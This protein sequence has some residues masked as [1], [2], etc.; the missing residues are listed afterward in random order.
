[1]TTTLSL[2]QLTDDYKA[3]SQQKVLEAEVVYE[4]HVIL[5]EKNK[6]ALNTFMFIFMSLMTSY[7]VYHDT[8]LLFFGIAFVLT[9]VA[10][11]HF[12]FQADN[13]Y[14]G[15]ITPEGVIIRKT[16]CVPEVFYA[17]T[18]YLA[19][20]GI[21]VCI[22]AGITLGSMIFAGAGAFAL[23]AFKM[24]GFKKVPEVKIK[25]YLDS[26]PYKL[27]QDDDYH[28][29]NIRQFTCQNQMLIHTDNPEDDYLRHFHWITINCTDKQYVEI[30]HH[31]AKF[32]TFDEVK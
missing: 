24:T 28:Q 22:I 5:K 14:Q 23:L 13:E 18:R 4:W 8:K 26:I 11:S 19:Y 32:I 17:A 30:K 20:I 1:M 25:P 29:N 31:L 3:S 15:Q 9:W 21:V 10:I 2:P 7:A 12:L 6:W 16:E 27:E